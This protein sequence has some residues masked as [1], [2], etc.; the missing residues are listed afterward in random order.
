MAD[1]FTAA[2]SI[3]RLANLYKDMSDAADALESIGKI[4]QIT[5]E[6]NA[7]A[8]A[9]RKQA[10]GA[11]ADLALVKDEVAKAKQ[12]AKDIVAKANDQ[13]LAKLGEA[14]QKAQA[15]LD[16]ATVEAN[17]LVVQAHQAA[18]DQS[19][20]VAGQVA[21]LTSTKLGLEGDIQALTIARNQLIADTDDLEK[22]VAKA[23]AYLAKLVS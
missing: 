6:Q 15:I 14:D 16:G 5:K 11:K 19:A 9:A 3:R 23:Q 13:A 17:R 22:R 21:Q 4:E 12:S 10:D 18:K 2:E 20:G 1:K 7:Q 8:D